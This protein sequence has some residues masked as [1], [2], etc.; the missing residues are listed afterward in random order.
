M[1]KEFSDSLFAD[2]LEDPFAYGTFEGQKL[3]GFV[4]E[5]RETWHSLFRITNRFVY[6]NTGKISWVKN[7]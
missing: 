3:L 4:E 5:S 1:E 2:W 7:H 6:G